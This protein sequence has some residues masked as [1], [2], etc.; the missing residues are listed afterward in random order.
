VDVVYA[1]TSFT[2]RGPAAD[3]VAQISPWLTL[4]ALGLAILVICRAIRRCSPQDRMSIVASGCVLVWLAFILT[5][6]VGSPQYLFWLCPL[7]PFLPL[8]TNGDRRWAGGF[9]I[10]A[11]LAT[12]VYPFM[13]L[14]VTGIAVSSQP[15]SWPGPNAIG[16]A[17]LVARWA[18]IAVLTVW[19]AVRLWKNGSQPG[20]TKIPTSS[21]ERVPEI[22]LVGA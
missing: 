4:V 21:V 18:S 12:L 15:V 13:W 19:L 8:K 17:L 16:L 14:S 9:I 5:N 7:V 10:A 20:A 11:L 3:T 2:I 1:F 6:K 22:E